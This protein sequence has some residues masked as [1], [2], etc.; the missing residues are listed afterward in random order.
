MTKSAWKTKRAV[1][2]CLLS[3]AVL[4]PIAPFTSAEFAAANGSQQAKPL[5]K[6]KLSGTVLGP[7][8]KPASKARVL[9]QTSDGRYPRTAQ[10]D[11]QGHFVLTC[12]AGMI[13]VR[14]QFQGNWS[15][16]MRNLRVRAGQ[17]V[18]ISLQIIEQPPPAADK[19]GAPSRPP[20]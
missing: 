1:W 2:L 7:N 9:A 5:P 3:A 8:G 15:E 12:P 13:D 20:R 17:T 10:T 19:T 4:V 11:A 16:W 6:G 14:A 18:S